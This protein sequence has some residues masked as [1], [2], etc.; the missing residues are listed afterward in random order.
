[1][2][3]L[4]QSLCHLW[5]SGTFGGGSLALPEIVC[6]VFASLLVLTVLPTKCSS[7]KLATY[8]DLASTGILFHNTNTKNANLIV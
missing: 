8:S 7:S 6:H 5:D 3:P 4:T 2:L 1:M